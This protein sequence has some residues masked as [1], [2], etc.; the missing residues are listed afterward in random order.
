MRRRSTRNNKGAEKKPQISP[1]PET[2]LVT[3]EFVM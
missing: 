3:T 2:L 1:S